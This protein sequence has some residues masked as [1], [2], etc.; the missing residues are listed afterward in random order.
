MCMSKFNIFTVIVF[1]ALN[2]LNAQTLQ[3]NRTVHFMEVSH[4]ALAPPL[5]ITPADHAT[6]VRINSTFTWHSSPGVLSYH[7]QVSTDSSF[8]IAVIDR[9]AL[10]DTTQRLAGLSHKTIYYWRVN[11]TGAEGTSPFSATYRFRSHVTPGDFNGSGE[12]QAVFAY[13]I[14]SHV[15]NISILTGDALETAEVSGDGAVS[16]Y[17]AALVLQ[18]ASGLLVVFPVDQ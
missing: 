5:P 3:G 1:V 6:G 14:L 13:F 12:I 7:L 16:A 8:A 15:A 2:S 9:P 17:D 4:T 18:V 11:A 10:T